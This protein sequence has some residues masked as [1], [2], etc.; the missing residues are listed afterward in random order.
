MRIRRLVVPARDES[1]VQEPRAVFLVLPTR[2]GVQRRVLGRIEHDRRHV[3][4]RELCEEP[5]VRLVLGRA[6]RESEAVPVRSVPNAARGATNM[7]GPAA[8]ESRPGTHDRRPGRD[9]GAP[10][11][12]ERP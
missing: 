12:R 9:K 8:R 4:R 2:P 10:A 7:T 11:S 1:V 5:L 3:H 6:R